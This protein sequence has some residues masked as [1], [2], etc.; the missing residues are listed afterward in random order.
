MQKNGR[1]EINVKNAKNFQSNIEKYI[2]NEIIIRIMYYYHSPVTV[3]AC[4][5]KF[6]KS[7]H[8]ISQYNEWMSN[9]LVSVESPLVIMTD[10]NSI[11][12]ITK[13]RA[14]RPTKIIIYQSIWEIM[15]ELEEIRNK[16]YIDSYLTKQHGIHSWLYVK[17]WSSLVEGGSYLPN[18]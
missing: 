4:Y 5:F 16:S 12:L 2:L 9:F 1:N 11:E 15:R 18:C 17:A 14:D 10:Q 8:S 7:K 13:K 6:N 3:I